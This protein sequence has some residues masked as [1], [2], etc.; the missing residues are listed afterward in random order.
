M[1]VKDPFSYSARWDSVGLTCS[2]CNYF[3]GPEKW[4]DLNKIS[5]C[6]LHKI[7]LSIELRNEGY[8]SSEWFC[9]QFDNKNA[10]PKAVK[11]FEG[12]VDILQDGIL[13]QANQSA[14]LVEHK[15]DELG[16]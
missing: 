13:Y 7:S 11:E 4:P 5:K 9:K 8:I 10:F 14:N 15:F 3:L 2:S 1:P 6:Q 12:I 16:K